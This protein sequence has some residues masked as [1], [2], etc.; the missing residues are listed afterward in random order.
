MD[1]KRLNRRDFLR[2]SALTAAGAALAACGPAPTPQVVQE[3]V[4]VPVEQTVVV[5]AT[6]TPP[7]APTAVLAGGN[8][9]CT[10]VWMFE[11]LDVLQDQMEDFY[12]ENPGI[13]IESVSWDETRFKAM[14]AAG[15]PPD[16][17]RSS[18]RQ[19]AYYVGRGIPLAIDPYIEVSTKVTWDDLAPV[20][21]CMRW[22]GSSI[23]SGPSYGLVKD[24]SCAQGHWLNGKVYEEV[25]VPMPGP[26]DFLTYADVAEVAAQFV[27]REG[28]R[29]LRFGYSGGADFTTEKMMQLA[30]IENDVTL[31]DE[32]YSRVNIVDNEPAYDMLKWL[33]DL[34]EKGISPSPINPHSGWDAQDFGQ[35]K[36]GIIQDG[37]WFSALL[38]MWAADDPAVQE[39][40]DD[41]A[42]AIMVAGVGWG[43]KNLNPS[44]GASADAIHS[45]S[46]CP[47][48]AWKVLEY[49]TSGTPAINRASS[50]W[51]VPPLLSLYPLMPKET[52]FDQMVQA[53]QQE[54]EKYANVALQ[55][56]PYYDADSLGGVVW[57]Q[58]LEQAL[59]GSITFDELVQ[60]VEDEVNQ[61]IVDGINAI[62]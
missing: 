11:D 42:V 40:V 45:Q 21:S 34:A 25:G 41:G 48:G 61:M 29:T 55:Q 6:A 51:G 13:T 24:W 2:L 59:N 36:I 31:Y 44:F 22:D 49:Y 30:C 23:G 60:N 58:N 28:D 46:K 8:I 37:Y 9:E 16:V 39:L 19:T 18:G 33:Y 4:E 38:K 35:G 17:Y 10:V 26:T 15:T 53:S 3:T 62:S 50:G 43:K 12:A 7:P 14:M 27:T 1:Q 52:P 56:N 5:Q 47:D 32:Y 20:H 54:Q 57:V